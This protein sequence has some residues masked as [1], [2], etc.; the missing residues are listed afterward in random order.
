MD[1]FGSGGPSSYGRPAET[2][3]TKRMVNDG[4]A[5]RRSIQHGIR[6]MLQVCPGGGTGH[7]RHCQAPVE[8]IGQFRDSGGFRYRVESC[9]EHVDALI[10]LKP[11][12]RS[13]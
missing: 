9:A 12:H 1:I 8:W 6:P 11:I 13:A 5:V 10:D 3:R 7:A 4:A 2:S